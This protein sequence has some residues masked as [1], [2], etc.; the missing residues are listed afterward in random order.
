MILLFLYLFCGSKKPIKPKTTISPGF[1]F[2]IKR[3]VFEN[4]D[5]YKTCGY[6]STQ[7]KYYVMSHFLNST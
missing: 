1:I 7:V 4:M 2:G 6:F 3:N 5:I